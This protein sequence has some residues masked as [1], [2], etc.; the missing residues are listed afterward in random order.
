MISLVKVSV[1]EIIYK[2]F[3]IRELMMIHLGKNPRNGGNPPR[4]KKLIKIDILM[5]GLKFKL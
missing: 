1:S 4:D 3:T 5:V 2:L